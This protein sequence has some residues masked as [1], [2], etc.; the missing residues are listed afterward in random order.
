MIETRFL[1]TNFNEE[2]WEISIYDNIGIKTENS[3][4]FFSKDLADNLRYIPKDGQVTIRIN[5]RGGDLSDTITMCGLLEERKGHTMCIIDGLCMSCATLLACA[6]DTIKMR[7]GALFMIHNPQTQRAGDIYELMNGIKI[8]ENYK[9]VSLNFYEKKTGLS[10]DVL[11]GMMD[12]GTFLSAEEAKRANFCDEI[13]DDQ[14]CAY[15]AGVVKNLNG[16]PEE[17]RDLFGNNNMKG[18]KN[19]TPTDPGVENENGQENENGATMHGTA[20]AP[21]PEQQ[22]Q[23]PVNNAHDD[24]VHSE[25][26]FFPGGTATIGGSG[27]GCGCQNNQNQVTMQT[28]Q[29]TKPDLTGASL[30]TMQEQLASLTAAFAAQ[31]RKN[32]AV[33]VDNA[34]LDGRIS[35]TEKDNWISRCEKD[36][37]MLGI[38]DKLPKKEKQDPIIDEPR[39]YQEG[40]SINDIAVHMRELHRA[41]D[42]VGK[43]KWLYDYR[44]TLRKPIA[45]NAITVPAD[46]KES[47]ILSDPV[48]DF[49]ADFRG[50]LQCFSTSFTNM[51]RLGDDRM[52][53]SKITTPADAVKDYNQANGLETGSREETAI[54]IS[55]NKHK[56]I[57]LEYSSLNIQAQPYANVAA[58]IKVNLNLLQNAVA[59]DI[60]SAIVSS[61]YSLVVDSAGVDAEDYDSK[62]V[63]KARK[64]C[65]KAHWPSQGRYLVLNADYEEALLNDVNLS[66]W[67][68]SAQS[69][70]GMTQFATFP[71]LLRGFIPVFNADI[72]TNNQKLVGFV[73]MKDA[74]GI[75]GAPIQIDPE[76]AKVATYEVI[77][78][79]VSGMTIGMQ[80]WADAQYRNVKHV[81][82]ILY[83]FG[84]INTASLMRIISASN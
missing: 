64:V 71:T 12:A 46:L 49:F 63:T 80:H 54:K 20:P 68:G 38:L 9:N 15:C 41:G 77:Q 84:P 22:Q 4:G 11:S 69:G 35:N 43:S 50:L 40:L 26:N 59:S 1:V 65:K 8:L 34:I 70:V 17:F 19:I 56:T 83:G 47:W 5:S 36:A 82:E 39:V 14:A 32:I 66:T 3:P 74:L 48:F 62:D 18:N 60:L 28:Q 23:Q 29:I 61:N 75:V 37:T 55:L 21:A 57:G 25:P 27:C 45:T 7:K 78:D 44:E 30:A 67:A 16:I 42:F 79:P 52:V 31:N 58:H 73:C 53:I 6:C 76:V 10:R 33:M 2:S 51:P 24:N 72:P 81:Y 13:I